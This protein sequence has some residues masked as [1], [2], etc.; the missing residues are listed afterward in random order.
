MSADMKNSV[1]ESDDQCILEWFGHI[2][3][4]EQST[5]TKKGLQGGNVWEVIQ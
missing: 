4:I 3:R 5:S 1:D 2:E